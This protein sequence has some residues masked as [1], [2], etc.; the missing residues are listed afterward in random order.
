MHTDG[1][2]Q[3]TA[4]AADHFDTAELDA[5]TTALLAD[6]ARS[7]AL[8]DPER[9]QELKALLRDIAFGAAMMLQPE[10]QLK[11][12]M[13]GYVREVRRVADAGRSV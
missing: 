13:L 8:T 3:L 5:D 12:A 7:V 10:M 4:E 6:E 1:P 11:G 9:V 2:E